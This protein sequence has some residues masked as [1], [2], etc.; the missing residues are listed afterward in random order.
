MALFPQPQV[1]QNPMM[2][3]LQAAKGDPEGTYQML[4]QTN[5]RFAEFVR[6]NQG[7]S[8]QQIAQ[9]NG[10]DMNMLKRFM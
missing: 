5:P 1:P 4:M 10:I 8:P 7:K 2:S 3:L 6:K 9:E